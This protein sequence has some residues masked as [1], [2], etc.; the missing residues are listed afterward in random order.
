MAMQAI[1]NQP[2]ANDYFKRAQ[3]LD[4]HGRRGT[5]AQAALHAH[6]VWGG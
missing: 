5:L 2:A 1:G 6:S 3:E 4:P